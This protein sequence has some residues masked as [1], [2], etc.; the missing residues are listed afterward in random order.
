[1]AA[2]HDLAFGRIIEAATKIDGGAICAE[3]TH[4]LLGRFSLQC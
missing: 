2:D 1:M 3:K 4:A